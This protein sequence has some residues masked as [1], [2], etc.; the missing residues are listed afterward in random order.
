MPIIHMYYCS[1][2]HKHQDKVEVMIAG[3]NRIN[4]CNE[5]I[6]LCYET[7]TDKKDKD[8]AVKTKENG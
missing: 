6:T 5:C 8:S 1:F 7:I 3:P 4:I 2:C